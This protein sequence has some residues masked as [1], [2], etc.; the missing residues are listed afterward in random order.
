MSQPR[1]SESLSSAYHHVPPSA[2]L[3]SLP[4][5]TLTIDCPASFVLKALSDTSTWPTWNSFV[6]KCEIL[7]NIG[8]STATN[9]NAS[10]RVSSVLR[11]GDIVAFNVAMDPSNP[12]QT[13]RRDL[14]LIHKASKPSDS[15]KE[16]YFIGWIDAPKEHGGLGPSLLKFEHLWRIT[17]TGEESCELEHWNLFAGWLT[18]PTKWFSGGA[19]R[20]LHERQGV[21]LK[22]FCEGEWK[23]ENE[24]RK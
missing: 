23:K 16:E 13:S 17:K 9:A 2:A 22:G 8:D 10:E 14:H 11:E 6:P 4:G 15:E 24:G 21:E 12:F 1:I 7:D 20:V 18:Y 3:L 19:L 5:P